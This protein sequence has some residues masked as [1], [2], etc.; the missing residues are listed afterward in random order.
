MEEY[1][2]DDPETT[3]ILIHMAKPILDK[4]FSETGRLVLELKNVALFQFGWML[5]I[6]IFYPTISLLM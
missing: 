5:I 3:A 4:N 2:F 6:D 1:E